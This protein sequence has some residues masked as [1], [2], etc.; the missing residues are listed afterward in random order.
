MKTIDES[1]RFNQ[2]GNTWSW[3]GQGDILK[4]TYDGQNRWFSTGVNR[5]WGLG[6]NGLEDLQLTIR[7]R[8]DQPGE[9]LVVTHPGG[10]AELDDITTEK[11][12]LYRFYLRSTMTGEVSA[13]LHFKS[14]RTMVID[15]INAFGPVI[16]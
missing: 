10:T 6:L 14:N 1:M 3:T 8:A 15:T 7:L 12:S 9:T 2:P 5:D 16:P 13:H 11:P 4:D